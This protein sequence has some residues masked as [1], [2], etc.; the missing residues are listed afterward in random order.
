MS[1]PPGTALG[2]RIL[3]VNHAGENGAI[4][5]YL[6]QL[7]MARWTAPSMLGQLR[8]FRAHEEEHRAIFG[9]E[10]A[11]RGTRRC[12]SYWLCAAGGYVLGLVTGLGGAQAIAAT[13]YAVEHVVLQHLRHQLAT[14]NG[15]DEAACAAIA[16]IIEDEQQHHDQSAVR[17][18]QSRFWRRTLIP[19][20]NWSTASVIWL[21]MRL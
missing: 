19:V 14:L 12:R 15:H 3:K 16:R 10:M 11:R 1:L 6:G 21:G 7:Q 18:G 20:V 4:H 2:S 5:I 8:Q 17:M 13:T 9:E